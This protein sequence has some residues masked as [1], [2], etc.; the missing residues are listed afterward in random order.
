M[1]V[2]AGSIVVLPLLLLASGVAAAPSTVVRL[3]MKVIGAEPARVATETASDDES[4][5]CSK[6]RKR[7]WIQGE[8]W[9]VRKV[10]TC[11]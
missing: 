6:S 8:G 4:G 11:R 9:I 5:T 7:L 1:F 10:T 2:K 3:P